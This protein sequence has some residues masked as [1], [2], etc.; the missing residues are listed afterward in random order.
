MVAQNFYFCS[1]NPDFGSIK[2]SSRQR[3]FN[4]FVFLI[5]GCELTRV[6][7]FSIVMRH[8]KK[9]VDSINL[10]LQALVLIVFSL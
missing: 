1:L 8:C 10:F 5:S 3:R 9:K 6:I 2:L 4:F 7:L